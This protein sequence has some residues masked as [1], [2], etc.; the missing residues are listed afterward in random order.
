MTILLSIFEYLGIFVFAISGLLTA[1]EKRLDY[2]GGMVIAF[3]TALGGGTI[4]DLLLNTEVRWMESSSL[5]FTALSGAVIGII[6][7][8]QLIHLKRTF[9]IF[10]TIGLGLFTILGI[11]KGLEFQQIPV[12]SLFLGLISATFGGVIRD[13]LC[14]EIPLIFR[15][16]IY[17]TAGIVGGLCYLGFFLV[18]WNNE[19]TLILG[20]LII[21]LIR[22][23]SVMFGWK[24]PLLSKEN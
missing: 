19:F 7:K 14:N 20:V 3:F 24:M 18:G 15:K 23:L 21:I 11:Q 2:F 8:Q 4:R 1:S 12:T 9:F 16:E 5:I 10:D 6:F 13:V 22:F 17:A